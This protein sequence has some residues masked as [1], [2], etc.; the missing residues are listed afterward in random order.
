MKL[1][2]LSPHWIQLAQWAAPEPFYIGIS[3]LC[4]HCVSSLK[5]C[6]TCGHCP[7]AKRVAVQF[8]PPIDPAGL[9]GRTFDLPNNNGHRRTGDTFQT[10][11]LQPSIKFE[12]GCNWH[13][14]ITNGEVQ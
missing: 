13:G 12:G 7:E 11:T 10:L 14:S 8:W 3:F 5:A 6:P 2:D 9:L 1:T 4:P